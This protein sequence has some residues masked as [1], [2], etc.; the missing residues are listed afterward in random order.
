[1]RSRVDFEMQSPPQRH[2]HGGAVGGGG[3]LIRHGVLSFLNER[4]S[5]SEVS[6]ITAIASLHCDVIGRHP[7]SGGSNQI[8]DMSPLFQ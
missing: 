6:A 2:A 1:M 7:R 5:L 3:W 8:E 4:E